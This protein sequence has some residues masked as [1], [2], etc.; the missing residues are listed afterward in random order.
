[1]TVELLWLV[2]SDMCENELCFTFK[3]ICQGYFIQSGQNFPADKP[4]KTHNSLYKETCMFGGYPINKAP[5]YFI[6]KL[7]LFDLHKMIFIYFMSLQQKYPTYK[8]NNR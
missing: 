6:K 1:M 4:H 8:E 3:E 5:L 7:A 2:F